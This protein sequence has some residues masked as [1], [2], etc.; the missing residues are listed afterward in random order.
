[1]LGF[2]KLWKWCSLFMIKSRRAFQGPSLA[3]CL[4]RKSLEMREYTYSWSV[5]WLSQRAT[6]SLSVTDVG[7]WMHRGEGR[8]IPLSWVC[9]SFVVSFWKPRFPSGWGLPVREGRRRFSPRFSFTWFFSASRIAAGV[10]FSLSSMRI[11]WKHFISPI[12]E[13]SC[14]I[15]TDMSD[16]MAPWPVRCQYLTKGR[17]QKK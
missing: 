7:P 8:S 16:W 14:L 6:E 10:F 2:P 4:T 13:P 3:Y 17:V 15:F 9:H 1:M 12:R 5:S 11:K